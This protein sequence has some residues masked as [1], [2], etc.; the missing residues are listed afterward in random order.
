MRN[1]THKFDSLRTAVA[2]SFVT[3]PPALRTIVE[4][5]NTEKG[6]AL[7]IARVAAIMAAKK[8]WEILPLC[9]QIPITQLDVDYGFEADGIR[10]TVTAGAVAP[11]G[12]EMEAMTAASVCALTLYDVLKPYDDAVEVGG[13]RLLSKRG[14]KSDRGARLT[15]PCTF[16]LA[17]TPVGLPAP[18][19]GKLALVNTLA[20]ADV[21]LHLGDDVPEGRELGALTH[22]LRTHTQRRLPTAAALDTRAISDGQRLHVHSHVPFEF[23]AVTLATVLPSAADLI[24]THRAAREDA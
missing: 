2:E 11:T 21:V 12:V 6:D 17:G 20:D 5:R 16:Y 1:I 14:G 22:A 19:A 3:M 4:S 9:H 18:A 13:T 7:E 15:P 23:L 8:T 24:V 10:V